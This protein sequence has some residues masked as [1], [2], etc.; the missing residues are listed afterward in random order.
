M[1]VDVA[2]RT[3]EG[4][5]APSNRTPTVD[6]RIDDLTHR[7]ASA[8]AFLKELNAISSLPMPTQQQV[9]DINVEITA[10]RRLK[11]A[12]D[13][14]WEEANWQVI[15][16]PTKENKRKRRRIGSMQTEIKEVL[17]PMIERERASIVLK[18]RKDKEALS[19]LERADYGKNKWEF[20]G[21]VGLAMSGIS[22]AI[23]TIDDKSL[24]TAL[25]LK[26]VYDALPGGSGTPIA[27]TI[28]LAGLAIGIVLIAREHAVHYLAEKKREEAK[29]AYLRQ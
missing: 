26:E 17:M 16:N 12:V 28:A 8:V 14:Y 10:H 15:D 27:Y 29:K 20:F 23:A 11:E 1:A 13:L 3:R 24:M 18:L 21:K 9:D 4:A 6:E 19:I 5:A 25:G 7:I 22:L 2:N